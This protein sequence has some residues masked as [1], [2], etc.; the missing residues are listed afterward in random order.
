M[1]VEKSPPDYE[2]M[3]KEFWQTQEVVD[4]AT[5]RA[6]RLIKRIQLFI[7]RFGYTEEDVLEKIKAD[8]MFA[9]HFTKEPRRLSIHETAAAAYICN[10]VWSKGLQAE[11]RH[12]CPKSIQ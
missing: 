12:S 5:S 1:W 10:L 2:A 9:A 6:E 3:E 4:E 7:W 11:V 8:E